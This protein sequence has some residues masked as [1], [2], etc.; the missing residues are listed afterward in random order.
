[1]PEIKN[2]LEGPI[3]HVNSLIT[4]KTISCPHC[5]RENRD[6]SKDQQIP[7]YCIF[8]GPYLKKLEV[9]TIFVKS[10]LTCNKDHLPGSYVFDN[11][12]FCPGCGGKLVTKKSTLSQFF[13]DR[14]I[15]P[16]DLFPSIYNKKI[17]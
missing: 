11:G 16:K 7:R 12:T 9:P 8:C 3:F 17:S 14:I 10:C 4:Y 13:I 15:F 5:G 1:M 2:F 6:Y